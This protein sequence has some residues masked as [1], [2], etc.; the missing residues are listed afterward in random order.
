MD[1]SSTSDDEESTASDVENKD[2]LTERND[3]SRRP[4]TSRFIEG[5]ATDITPAEPQENKGGSAKTTSEEE[6]SD[7]ILRRSPR[8]HIG[9]ALPGRGVGPDKFF[10]GGRGNRKP[11]RSGATGR[12]ISAATAINNENAITPRLEIFILQKLKH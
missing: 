3:P 12:F 10:N 6:N 1:R 4:R 5:K 11:L 7:D 2:E 9:S 8:F